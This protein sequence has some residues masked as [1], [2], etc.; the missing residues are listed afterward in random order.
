MSTPALKRL[1]PFAVPGGL[2]GSLSRL[3]LPELL[4]ELQA[5]G[6]TGILSLT[7]SG[8]R[9]ALYFKTGRVVF[10]TSNQ[11]KDRLGEILVRS[12]RIT[13]E[14]NAS[15]GRALGLGRRQGRVLVEQGVL[16]PDELWVAVQTQVREIVF[17]V[18]AW[19]EG[20]FHFEQS[21][22]PERERI[23]VD[24]DVTSLI[25]EGVRRLAP[26]GPIRS[27]YGDPQ[28]VLER[29][30]LA[31][32]GLLLAWEEH[33]LTLVDGE[34]TVFEI[35]HESEAGEGQTQKALYAL[36]S[37]GIVRSRGRKARA[38]LDQDFVPADSVLA[39]LDSF[40]RMY[41]LVCATMVREVGPIAE[42]VLAKYLKTVRE[43]HPQVLA[44]VALRKDGS[45]DETAV[46]RN[47]GR[48]PEEHRR[49]ALVDALN[50]LLYA[51]LLAVKR[52]LG[53][54]HESVLVRELR[55]SH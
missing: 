36:L 20:S 19:D 9:K 13:E 45:I 15:A 52:T 17:S 38:A 40:N 10:A 21:V 28:L 43:A 32:Q 25:V 33:V 29:G 46:E 53:P 39:L 31:P 27:R 5:A 8:A 34:R 4:R 51:E 11:A 54:D 41:C 6:A 55:A 44:E 47:L 24:L 37:T 3:T 18:I 48:L 7:E 2:R 22:L 14:Q 30:E 26:V 35:C 12:G 1:E 16:T 49:A 50:E 42:N 23:T